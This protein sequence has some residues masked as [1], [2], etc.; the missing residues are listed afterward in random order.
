MVTDAQVRRLK[1]LSKM[2][3]NQEIAAAKAGM[4]AK[5]ARKYLREGRLPSENR[6]DRTWR[7][8]P[9]PFTEVWEEVRQLVD[10]NPG[11]EAKTL[12]EALQR[13][14]P[15]RFADGQLR[16]LQRRLKHWRATEGPSREVFFAQKHVPG[17]LGQSDFTHMSELGITIGGQSF[18]HLLYHF[19]LTYSNWES[20]S[21]CYSESFE[22][23]S[24]GLQNALWELGGAPL[25][26]RTDRMS[27]AVNNMSEAQEF[28]PRYE[29]LLRH[30]RLEGQKI[31]TGK[32]N[33]NGD[34]EQRHHR[35]KRAVDQALML[36]ASRDFGALAGYQ[37]FLRAL[38]VHLNAGRRQRLAEEMQYL[39]ALP[40]RRLESAKRVRVK[41]DSG[42]LIY[43]DRNTYSVNSRLIGEP[44]EARLG[45]ERIEV[46]YAGRKVEELP[47][48]RG[49]GKHRV[50]YRHII[51][52]LVRKPG[53]FE[54]YRYRE[55]M[56]PT[57]RFRMVWDALREVI[58]QRANKRYLALLEIAAKEGEARVDDAFRCL[59]E[60][61]E[62]GEGKL[63]VEAV[64]TLLS[65]G[66][67]M[68]PATHVAV[69]DVSLSSFDE[70]LAGGSECV[71]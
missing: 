16:T 28:T 37:E 57:S 30:Y 2:E 23:L 26:H 22:S 11:L 29:G 24:D 68:L 38:L 58:P 9:D 54:N 35:L 18:P 8:R 44:V 33:E 21:I 5:T 34:I 20:A 3:Q 59:L 69:S 51:D 17:R 41:V 67:N 7:T 36:R 14:H 50:D 47:R 70:L 12:F 27:T 63:S 45:A 64:R 55:E 49:R 48:L 52:W 66:T 39:R 13:E 31:Q 32:A 56:F 42:S 6:V 62:I 1:R 60:Q 4:D 71:Q 65:Q 19:V 15:G 40:E 25:E 46:W 10:A 61:G 43:V 53:A